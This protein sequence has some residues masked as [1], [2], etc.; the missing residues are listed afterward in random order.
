MKGFFDTLKWKVEASL[1]TFR[2]YEEL[3]WGFGRE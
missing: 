3:A 2:F 1:E